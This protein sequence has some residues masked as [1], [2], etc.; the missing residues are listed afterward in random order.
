MRLQIVVDNMEYFF[1]WSCIKG[2]PSPVDKA[3]E[4]LSCAPSH[5]LLGL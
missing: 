4:L 3:A 1:Y 2:A 5:W